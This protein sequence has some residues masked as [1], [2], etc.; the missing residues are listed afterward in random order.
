MMKDVCL[1]CIGFILQTMIFLA[2]GRLVFRVL[3]LKEDISLQLILGYL[4]YFA[5]FEILFTPM[6][7]LWVSLSTAAGVWAV[8]MAVAVLGAFLCIRRHRHM[9]GTPGQ[10]VRVKAE[11]VWKQHSVMLLLLAAVIFLQCLI[12]IF[13]EDITVDAAYYVGTVSTSVYTN[14]LGRFDPACSLFLP[15]L[16]LYH[17]T[18]LWSKSFFSSL[19]CASK[20]IISASLYSILHS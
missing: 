10:T 9:D 11:A 16:Q 7:L 17:A 2:A 20:I 5:V 18:V 12:V 3:K 1:A 4:A 19:D 14:T 15:F 13:Y 8:I 6:T